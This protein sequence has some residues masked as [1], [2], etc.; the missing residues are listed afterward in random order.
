[1]AEAITTIV[2]GVTNRST[3][4]D[5]CQRAL[6]L[7]RA[8]D[9]RVHLV[10]AIDGTDPDGADVANRH[11]DGLLQTI[12]LSS[13]WPMT[14]HAIPGDPADVIL[15]V[16]EEVGADLIAIGNRGLTK[17]GRFTRETPAQIVKRAR[18]SVL[19]VDTDPSR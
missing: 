1:M 13:S 6:G 7:A 14:V 11:A 12:A 4:L 8:T 10:Y 15:A 18:C 3:A 19:V 17:H 16:A 9:A 5:A 2:I